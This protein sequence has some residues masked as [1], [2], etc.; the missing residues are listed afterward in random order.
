MG[1]PVPTLHVRFLD[2]LHVLFPINIKATKFRR[3]LFHITDSGQHPFLSQN[4]DQSESKKK[5]YYYLN[6]TKNHPINET[7]STNPNLSNRD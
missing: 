3:T 4:L 2:S 7:Y 1:N 5:S 6:P